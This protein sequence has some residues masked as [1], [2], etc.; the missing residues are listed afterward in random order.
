[1]VESGRL[2]TSDAVDGLPIC[3]ALGVWIRT[4]R[5]EEV[6]EGGSTRQHA[7]HGRHDT[8][9]DKQGDEDEPVGHVNSVLRGAELAGSAVRTGRLV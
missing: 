4:F 9:L 6:A 5:E 2:P 8:K 3:S 7:G 1:M